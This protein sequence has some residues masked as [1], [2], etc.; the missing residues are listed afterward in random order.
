MVTV[1]Y[2]VGKQLIDIKISNTTRNVSR[3]TQGNLL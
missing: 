3:Q 2:T 1:V